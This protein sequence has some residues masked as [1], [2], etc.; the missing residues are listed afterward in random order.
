MTRVASLYLPYWSIDRMRRAER[1]HA[2]RPEADR[3]RAGA[4]AGA[5]SLDPIDFDELGR[6]AADERAGQCSVPDTPGWRPGARWA[7]GEVQARIASLPTHRQP[8]P[9]ELGRSSVAAEA[10]FRTLRADDAGAYARRGGEETAAAIEAMPPHR[11]PPLRE[12]GRRNETMGQPFHAP[13]PVAQD[14]APYPGE[15]RFFQTGRSVGSLVARADTPAPARTALSA[16]AGPDPRST[17]LVI[18]CRTGPRVTIAAACPAARALGLVAGMALTHARAS[19]PASTTLDVRDADP[20]GDAADLA[21]LALTLARRWTPVVAPSGAD[22]LLLDLT[23][24]AHLHGGE[25]RMARR[26]VRLLARHGVAARVA[27]ADT[28]GAAWALARF[29]RP[30]TAQAGDRVRG[31]PQPGGNGRGTPG[32]SHGDAV[33]TLPG[34]GEAVLIVPAGGQAD[35]LA[36]LPVAALRIAPRPAELLARL[37]IDTVGQLVAMP[38]AP[39]ARR[40]GAALLAR[41]DQAS[42]RLPEP[43][44][45]VVPREPIVARQRF[46]EPI[47]TADAIAHWLGEL[48][49]RLAEALARGGLG[50]RLVELVADR[51]DGVPQTIRVGLARPT[52]DPVHLLRL[53]ARRIE[54]IDPGYGIDALALHVRRADPLG[55]QE[56]EGRP[57]G[58]RPA[59]DAPPDL[60]PLVDALANRIGAARLW[61]CRPVESDVPERSVAGVVPLDPPAAEARAV[62]AD[63]V[64]R[65][66]ARGQDHPW[67]PRWPRPVRLLRRPEPVGDVIAGLPDQPPRRF[68]WRG[69]THRVVCADGPERIAGEWWRRPGEAQAVRDYFRV[70]VEAGDRFWLYRR[71]DGVRVETGDLAWFLHGRFG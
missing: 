3:H 48:M 50:A 71:G 11:R 46:A 20:A 70:E 16:I 59:E 39:L 29:G 21:R 2:P 5:A 49:P 31:G 30:A 38:R 41:L 14:A 36:P 32:W 8:P 6:I 24:V 68:T 55:P 65:L 43:L 17:P 45:P 19:L 54:E 60:A 18:V 61:R 37:G 1:T 52:R 7:R 42:G 62:A 4:G 12:L 64:R 63:D 58:V 35:A 53:I 15:G 26:L 47:A 66:D 27:V 51:V 9:R 10:P 25:A 67:H 44:D 23:G 33:A 56:I 22:G 69:R 28:V 13:S 57:L 40:F 34:G